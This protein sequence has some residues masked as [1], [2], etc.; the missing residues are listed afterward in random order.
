LTNHSARGEPSTSHSVEIDPHAILGVQT[1]ASLQQIREAYHAKALKHHPD[2]GGDNWAFQIVAR[3][4]EILGTRRV[5]ARAADI[6]IRP[7]SDDRPTPLFVAATEKSEWL[8]P[9]RRDK[10]VEPARLVNIEMLLLRFEMTDPTELLF[11]SV[12]DRNL[13]CCLNVSWAAPEWTPGAKLDRMT[14]QVPPLLA[15]TLKKIASKTRAT[16]SWSNAEGEKFEGWLSY[17]TATRAWESFQKLHESLKSQG[18]GVNQWTR[19]MLIPRV[20]TEASSR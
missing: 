19:E 12:E 5:A 10:D 4:Y 15:K 11:R 3:A 8:R 9:G 6:E 1:G 17:P 2:R 18:L 20:G 7:A 14:L 13:S 16:A